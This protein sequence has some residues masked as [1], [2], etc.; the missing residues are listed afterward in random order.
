MNPAPIIKLY[1]VYGKTTKGKLSR[2]S[3]KRECFLR[4]MHGLVD[5]Q[6]IS[7]QKY[8]SKSFTVNDY[9]SFKTQK[10]PS[11]VFSVYGIPLSL[12]VYACAKCTSKLCIVM[13]NMH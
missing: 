11:R 5:Q 4:I 9:F 12:R 13:Y 10:F 7:P 8:Y 1:T 2:F 6:C 3:L